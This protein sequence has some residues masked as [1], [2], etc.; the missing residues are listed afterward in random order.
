MYTTIR[1]KDKRIKILY[2]CIKNYDSE[3]RKI[4]TEEGHVRFLQY[5]KRL[6]G[7]EEGVFL[8]FF[9]LD[10][11]WGNQKNYKIIW[12]YNNA[13]WRMKTDIT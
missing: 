6:P 3:R 8:F 7:C 9:L 2:R 5:W 1:L 12:E 10:I 4:H 11:C 13:M